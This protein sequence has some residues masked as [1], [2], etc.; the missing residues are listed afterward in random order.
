MRK[1]T[2]LISC[3]LPSMLIQAQNLV[4]NPDFELYGTVPCGWT[5]TPMDFNNAINSW[6]D[7]TQ[8]TP[9]IQST[10]ISQS[11]SNFQPNSTYA[12]CTNGPQAPHSGN[13]FAGFYTQVGGSTWREYL[14]VQLTSPMVVGIP[15]VVQLYVSLGDES[16]NATNNIGVGFSTTVTN[17]GISG[18]LG[19]APQVNF[20]NVISDTSNWVFLSDTLVPTQPYEFIIIGNFY[21]DAG[22][23]VATL[24]PSACWDRAYYYCDDVMIRPIGALV[25]STCFGDSTQF[26]LYQN[27]AV[28]A[29]MWDFGDPASGPDNLA[30]IANPAHLFTAPGTYSVMTV[31]YYLNGSSDTMYTTVNIGT[32]PLIS[33]GNDTTLCAGD[34]I[35]L[36][37]GAGFTSY[38]WSDG[39]TGSA[40]TVSTAGTLFVEVNDNGCIGTDTIT[41]SFTPCALPVVALASSDTSWCD[42]KAIDYFDL[43]TNNPTSWHWYFQGAQPDTSTLQNPTG[44]YYPSYGSFDVQLVACNA[45][46]CDTLFL[47]AFINEY[48]LPPVPVISLIQ[49]T[50]FCSPAYSYQ[51]YLSPSAIPGATGSFYVPQ[52]FGDYFVIIT[53][54]N[55]CASASNSIV[56]TGIPDLWQPDFWQ[57][58]REIRV[59][60]GTGRLILERSAGMDESYSRLNR[61]CNTLAPGIYIITI[62]GKKQ[63][64]NRKVFVSGIPD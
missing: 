32:P 20:T 22:T 53:D 49:D 50:L 33:L 44:I 61:E 27:P 13:I 59:F 54:S 6:T 37:A 60:D 40:L 39:S 52:Q 17:S 14:Q 23:S 9:D 25:S 21:N 18:E 42:K 62:T 15:Y 43:S 1:I 64:V 31:S 36:N 45:S 11:C 12:G 29:N 2:F 55:G 41:V 28:I 56:I 24:Y 30:Y 57:Q 7:P 38:L 48:Q 34:S 63:Q 19:Y 35:Q 16:Q 46:G 4:P 8:A 58:A 5:A 3:F 26:S 47:P 10:L 51:W